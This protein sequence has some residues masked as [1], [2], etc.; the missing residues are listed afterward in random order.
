MKKRIIRKDVM[1]R[2]KDGVHFSEPISPAQRYEEETK[3]GTASNMNYGSE[4]AGGK[5]Q[6]EADEEKKIHQQE[7]VGVQKGAAQQRLKDRKDEDYHPN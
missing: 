4:V 3:S 5:W 7:E 6:V 2:A 1:S